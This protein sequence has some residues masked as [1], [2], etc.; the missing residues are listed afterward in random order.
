VH[1]L[2]KENPRSDQQARIFAQ[3]FCFATVWPIPISS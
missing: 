2:C 1:D 3:V